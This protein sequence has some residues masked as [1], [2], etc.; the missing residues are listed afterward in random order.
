MQNLKGQITIVG[1]IS[2]L[3]V[4]V[5]FSAIMPLLNS[6]IGNASAEADETTSFLLNLIP[7]FIVIA[8]IMSIFYYAKPY[9]QRGEEV[10]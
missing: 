5:V 7:F 9:F 8:I 4:L 1:I 10:S 6:V 2:I 3:V